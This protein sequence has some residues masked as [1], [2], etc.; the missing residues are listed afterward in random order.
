MVSTVLEKYKGFVERRVP[1]FLDLVDNWDA[2]SVEK[3]KKTKKE[4][5]NTSIVKD[6]KLRKVVPQKHKA[7][8]TMW[9][10]VDNETWE[11]WYIQWSLSISNTLYLKLSLSRTNPLV[12][13]EFEIESP[14][15]CYW[16]TT[17]I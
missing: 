17:S 13:Y 7:N 11:K 4:G 6:L 2:L 12:P 1:T 3:Q 14:L 8:G 15:Y 10:D 9:V 16:L 5:A